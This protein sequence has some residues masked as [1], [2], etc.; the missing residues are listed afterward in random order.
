MKRLLVIPPLLIL[1]LFFWGPWQTGP[2][3]EAS[4]RIVSSTA[5]FPL[6]VA[7]PSGAEL[8]LDRPPRRILA[9]N[10]AALDFALALVGPERVVA[11][12]AAAEIYSSLAAVPEEE[13]RGWNALPRFHGYFAE[14]VLGFEPDVVL[15]H[16][17]QA[18]E[19]T[20]VLIEAGVPVLVAPLPRSWNEILETLALLGRVLDSEDRAGEILIDLEQRRE[21]L[22]AGPTSSRG[23]SAICYS[24][25]GA[26]G[27][28]AG[29]GTTA[30][31]LFELAGLRNAAA[32]AGLSGHE[33]IDHERLLALDPDVIV[34]GTLEDSGDRPPS[35]TYLL[36]QPVLRSLR[37]IQD[38]RIV[39]LPP[40]LFTTTS[41]ALLDA[42]ERLAAE[43]ERLY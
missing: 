35:E 38:K 41:L 29:A 43:V 42:A 27:T 28:T 1:G 9:A 18:P 7:M 26:G 11:L 32:D 21:A 23:L 24:N 37:A 25:L 2:L 5:G 36:N 10:A 8:Y 40:R 22:A 30:D 14:I 12:P 39:A 19:T 3:V 15:A 31:V 4:P 6:T 20:A 13:R 16:S 17:W 34:V 33:T